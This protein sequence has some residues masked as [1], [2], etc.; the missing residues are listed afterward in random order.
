MTDMTVTA[1]ACA[2]TLFDDDKPQYASTRF[3]PARPFQQSAH[4]AL[5]QGFKEGHKNQIIMAP[6]RRGMQA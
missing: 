2:S 1:P 6:K 3:P 5:R 4:A